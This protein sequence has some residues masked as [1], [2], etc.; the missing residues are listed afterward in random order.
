[1]RSFYT[2]A[3]TIVLG[4]FPTTDVSAFTISGSM[5]VLPVFA[6]VSITGKSHK[7]EAAWTTSL[8]VDA[9]M[10]EEGGLAD[11]KPN[12]CEREWNGVLPLDISCVAMAIDDSVSGG[13]EYCGYG[14]VTP[15]YYLVPGPPKLWGQ[16]C[17][18]AEGTGGY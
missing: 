1:M 13:C 3:I 10:Y 6:T 8:Q 16:E 17:H 4:M 11:H 2:L 7:F 12:W 9:Y 14:V 15:L 5:E 18:E